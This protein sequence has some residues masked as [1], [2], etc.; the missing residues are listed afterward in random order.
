MNKEKGIQQYP[1]D[2]LK[3]INDGLSKKTFNSK[4]PVGKTEDILLES[5]QKKVISKVTFINCTSDEVEFTEFDRAV[6]DVCISE[7]AKG[8]E[9]T[10]P[11]IIFHQLGGGH[12][13]TDNMK[14]AIMESIEKL[15]SVR[16]L[17]DMEEAVSKNLC[18]SKNGKSTF[19]GY[20]LPTESLETTI[21]GQN[22]T[23]IRFLS[24]GIIYGV[25]DRKNQII[26]CPQNL[27]TPPVRATPRTVAIN[28]HLLRRSLEIK[29]SRDVAQKNKRVQPMCKI[30]TLQ[31]MCEK[32][33]ID[34][35]NK[36]ARQQAR[37][38][39]TA[40]LNFFVDNGIIKNFHF[41]HKNGKIY[42]IVLEV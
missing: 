37:D 17:I 12:R 25:A 33:G 34:F 4:L 5:R 15:A 23:A 22:V 28:H 24:K 30:I 8:N 9:Y 36:R 27:L 19:K 42:S 16:I 35:E 41:E 7:Q 29:G 6:L 14:N 11:R 20:L 1:A 18:Q 26:T 40:I 31:D 32:C 10:T 13:L 39:A 38:T 3:I 2:S 21:N